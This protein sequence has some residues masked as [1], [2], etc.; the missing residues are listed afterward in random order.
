MISPSPLFFPC[1]PC[2]ATRSL[3]FIRNLQHHWMVTES[4]PSS[5]VPLALWG[6]VTHEIPSFLL[7]LCQSASAQ[8]ES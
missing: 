6:W 5:A 2:T 1:H 8:L 7:S 3:V 4:L